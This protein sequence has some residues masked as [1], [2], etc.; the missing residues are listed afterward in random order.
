[1]RYIN[2]N[3]EDGED[4]PG[5]A[6]LMHFAVTDGGQRDNG[7]VHGIVERPTLDNHVPAGTKEHQNH[8]QHYSEGKMVF[9][10]HGLDVGW[11]TS[12]NGFGWH[13]EGIDATVPSG[14]ICALLA[15]IKK[16]SL[17]VNRQ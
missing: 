7:H 5:V 1:M 10:L 3:E 12:V 11:P 4:S 16:A 15:T 13:G 9:T 6:H 2:D 8:G 14:L 17:R